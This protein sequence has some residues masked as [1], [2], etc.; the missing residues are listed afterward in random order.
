[1]GKRGN[2]Y[3]AMNPLPGD[4]NLPAGLRQRDIDA[5]DSPKYERALERTLDRAER[6]RADEIDRELDRKTPTQKPAIPCSH[7]GGGRVLELRVQADEKLVQTCLCA[8]NT[9]AKIARAAFQAGYKRAEG[10]AANAQGAATA[11]ENM[12]FPRLGQREEAV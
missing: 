4:S 3:H 2:F 12:I 1:M 6:R 8:G 9:V 11:T 10:D 7:C 5:G